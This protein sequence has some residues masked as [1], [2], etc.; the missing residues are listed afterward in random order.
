LYI[1]GQD[2]PKLRLYAITESRFF[3]KEADL[4]IEINRQGPGGKQMVI[5][6]YGGD[7][8]GIYVQ[9]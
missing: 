4:E 1:I 7:M 5:Y 3:I 9:N 8:V 2:Q 6:Q